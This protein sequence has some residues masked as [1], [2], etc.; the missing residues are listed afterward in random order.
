MILFIVSDST[1][2]R[3]RDAFTN[4]TAVLELKR[5]ECLC[6]IICKPPTVFPHKASSLSRDPCVDNCLFCRRS[7]H[8]STVCPIFF[9]IIEDNKVGKIAG[10]SSRLPFVASTKRVALAFKV[11]KQHFML[12]QSECHFF[13]S[14]HSHSSPNYFLW[15]F[16]AGLH[17]EILC[18]AEHINLTDYIVLPLSVVFAD[19]SCCSGPAWFIYI[20]KEF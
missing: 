6:V 14:W 7:S 5:K 8:L 18:S 13:S 1:K 17:E 12:K 16:L 10:V 4:T 2:N 15:S 20:R 19:F 11:Q 3:L 9:C